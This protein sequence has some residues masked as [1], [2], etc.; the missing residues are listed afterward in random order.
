MTGSYVVEGSLISLLNSEGLLRA[1]WMAVCSR[2]EA[3][4]QLDAPEHPS[5]TSCG[6]IDSFCRFFSTFDPVQQRN[7]IVRVISYH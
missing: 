6:W 4:G 2:P 1:R 5:G 3:D 7:N